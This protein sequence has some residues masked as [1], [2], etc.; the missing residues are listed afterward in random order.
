MRSGCR[1]D[2][3]VIPRP[4]KVDRCARRSC[5]HSSWRSRPACRSVSRRSRFRWRPRPP[6]RAP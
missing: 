2:R 6:L 3:P 1:D 5:L 4:T